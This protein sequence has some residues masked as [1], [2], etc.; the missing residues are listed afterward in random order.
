MGTIKK[1][2]LVL[3]ALSAIAGN[4]NADN[5]IW[6]G[7]KAGTLGVGLEGTWR[8]IDWLDIRLGGSKYDYNETGAQAGI[9]YDATLG[10]QTYYLTGNFRFPLSPFRV[11]AGLYSNSNEIK[12]VSID[13]PT[14]DI[15]GTTYTSTEVGTLTSATSWDSTSPYF[16]A[17]F[18]FELLGKVG[19]TFDFGVLWQGDPKVSLG[20]TGTLAGAQ[21]FLDDLETERAELTDKVDVLK[22]YPVV[23]LGFNFNF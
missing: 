18:D 12:M 3:L 16:G 14:F 11:T 1:Q 5:N 22:A 8:P 13:T 23:S 20:A 21:S 17:G 6:L 10:L 7:V 2:A 15:G 19:M 9:N 4:A